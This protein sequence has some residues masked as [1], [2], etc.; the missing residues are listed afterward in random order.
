MAKEERVLKALNRAPLFRSLN[1]RQLR[2]MARRFVERDYEAGDAIVTQ[3]KGGEGF[4]IITSG[5]AEAI[6]EGPD[7]TKTTVNTFGSNDFFGELAL[8][9]DG[10]RT[11]S[12]VAVEPTECLVLTRWDFLSSLKEDADSAVK[13]LQEVAKRFRIALDTL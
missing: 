11:A 13:V 2:S 4:F 7:G 10:P 3:G 9:D 6:R 5:E 12:V 1:K 8:L